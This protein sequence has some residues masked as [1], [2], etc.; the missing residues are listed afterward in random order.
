[1]NCRFC[2]ASLTENFCDLRASPPSNAFLSSDELQGPEI[3]YPL[4]VYVCTK[5]Y[6]AQIAE[7]KKSD[8]IFTKEYVYFSSFS[9]SWLEH[10]KNYSSMI[11]QRLGLNPESLVAEIAS[12]DGYLLKNFVQVKIPCFGIEPTSNTAAAAKKLGVPTI[13]SFFGVQLAQQLVAEDKKTDLLIGNNVLAHVPDI[14]DFV[15]GLKILLKPH[16]T[17]TME[18]PH[19]LNLLNENQFDTVYHEHYSYLSLGVTQAI[20]KAHGLRIY[21]VEEIPTHGG[22]LRIYATHDGHVLLATKDSVQKL[23]EKERS[24]GLFE[25]KTYKKFQAVVDQIK[26]SVLE[27]L[28]AAKKAEKKVIGYG[29]AAKGNTLL[30]FCGVDR[31]LVSFVVD[32]APSKIGKYLPGSRIPVFGKEKILAEKPN[33]ILILPWNLKEEIIKDL[34]YS[35]EWGCQ[36]VTFIPQLKVT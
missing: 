34:G 24:A 6:L 10:A 16:G 29:A 5:C 19:L 15:K 13:E 3:Y 18:F 9:K 20:F 36:F 21:D 2:A 11:T 22:S 35:R 32:A 7:V 25:L 12:N 1:M 28:L 17:V 33:Y 31:D 26:L 8:E 27:F 23:V 30:N 14:N 4:N